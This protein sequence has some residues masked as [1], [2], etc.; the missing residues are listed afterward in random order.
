MEMIQNG[1]NFVIGIDVS[2]A[3][4][5]VATGSPCTHESINNDVVSIKR[6]I[7]AIEM[8]RDRTLIVVEATGGYETLLVET[9]QAASIPV[10]VVNPRRVRDF[11]KGI[12]IDVK[13]DPIDAKV[14]ARY[15]EVVQPKPAQPKTQAQ[16]NLAALVVRRRQLLKMINM[17]KNRLALASN[18]VTQLI[19]DSLKAL[20]KQV[21]ILDT[22]IAK[23]VEFEK[24]STRKVEIMQSVKGMGPVA[25]STFIAELPELGELNR[26]QIAKLVGVAPINND[27]GQHHGKRKTFAGRSSVRR[28]LYMAA[29]VAT[30]H[31]PRIKAFYQRLLAGGKPK[32]LALVAA[33]RKLLTII[34]TLIKRDQL[35]TD[36]LPA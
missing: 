29:L 18:V 14:I 34:N 5:D 12:G 20:K 31:N 7:A 25:I 36:P 1:F 9:L 15:G 13:T 4:L 8:Q 6:L 10:A 35:W 33:M 32:K 16:K 30:R 17:E 26:G 11:A 24:N 19:K 21:K 22:E 23:A 2:K 3:R 28:V 27:S